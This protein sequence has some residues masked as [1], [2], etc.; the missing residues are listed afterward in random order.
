M[1]F[2]DIS[3][4][5]VEDDPNI[6]KEISSFLKEQIFS[7]VYIA[8]NGSEGLQQFYEYK[9]DIILTD[10]NMPKMNGL[11]MSEI[12]KDFNPK[13]P[14]LLIT[15]DFKKEVTERCVDIGIDG[16]LF[17]PISLLRLKK[18]LQS[19]CAR[20]LLQKNFDEKHKLLHEYKNAIDV[21]SAVSKTNAN[22]MIT[23][24][25]DAFCEVSGYLKEE[26]LGKNHNIIRHPDSKDEFFAQMWQTITKKQVW[27]G[28]VKN[29]KKNGDFFVAK[30][31]I[32]PIVDN[33]NEILEYIAIRQDITDLYEQERFL[34]KRIDEEVKKNL[35]EVKFS[36]IGKMA[37]GITHEINTPLTYIKGNLELMLQ[38]INSLDP[39]IKVKEYLIE[40][41]NTVLEGVN[42]IA[43][44]VES[45]R[46]VASQRSDVFMQHN[47]YS[48]LITALT[49]SYNKAKQITPIFVQNESFQI[50]MDKK[51]YTFM[52]Q[53]QIQRLEQ[54][55]IIIINN[56]LDVL[57][58]ID[59]FE[60]R[61]LDISIEE[62]FDSFSII[63]QDNGGGIDPKVLPN[64]FDPFHS[65]KEE[66]G[67]GIGLNVAQKI[68]QDHKGRLAALNFNDGARFELVIPKEQNADA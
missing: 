43:S 51:K 15:S 30:T 23:Y 25:N 47:L 34:K 24:V 53:I 68:I 66:G 28:H 31:S 21:S 62:E 57:K 40:D 36:S 64:I 32:V 22:G 33:K 61:K 19:Y 48:S 52:A 35:N 56:A 46:E 10:L 9:P 17:K 50:G 29:R 8:S 4:L 1:N 16:Y 44:I 7:E 12:I 63:F 60:Q 18:V 55:F 58:H 6:Q 38:D 39:A 11:A 54:V 49:I 27:Q 14:I 13:V 26:L 45:M 59:D 41:T 20:V 5:F 65:T 67:M 3:I 2:T 42:R 37:A